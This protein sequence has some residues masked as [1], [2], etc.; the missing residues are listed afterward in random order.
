MIVLSA[1]SFKFYGDFCV[2]KS[3]V[4]L[5]LSDEF[6]NSNRNEHPCAV[7]IYRY[8]CLLQSRLSTFF[9]GVRGIF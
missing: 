4:F 2:V 6:P 7:G 1:T 5:V 9:R 3:L 8:V